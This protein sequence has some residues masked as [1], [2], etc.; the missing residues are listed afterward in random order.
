[1]KM[2]RSILGLLAFVLIAAIAGD[3]YAAC[4][5]SNRIRHN[6][7][8]CL[9]AWW[10]NN[11]WPSRSEVWARNDCPS[12]GKVVAKIDIRSASDKTWHL[13]TGGTRYSHTSNRIRSVSCCKD[14]GI[15]MCNRADLVSVSSCKS[16]FNKSDA[17][18]DCTQN[19]NPTVDDYK[20]IFDLTCDHEESDGTEHEYNKSYTVSWH[21]ADEIM[22]CSSGSGD[23]IKFRLDWNSCYF[24]PEAVGGPM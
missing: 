6:D 17:S 1:M 23:S 15:K 8:E 10:D 7:V 20:C 22:F 18:D 2:R 5:G 11:S 21:R 12:W 4:T 24:G 9:H 13:T 16:Q 14:L 19:G 3:A